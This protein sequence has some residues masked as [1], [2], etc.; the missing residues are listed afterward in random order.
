MTQQQAVTIKVVTIAIVTTCAATFPW[1][2][3]YDG[4]YQT[5]VNAAG[6][7]A[8]VIG[9]IAPIVMLFALRNEPTEESPGDYR[10]TGSTGLETA[11]HSVAQRMTPARRVL[12]KTRRRRQWAVVITAAGLA[13][14]AILCTLERQR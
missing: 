8:A 9:T 6:W 3:S 10:H 7:G 2:L 13:A 11:D 12:T 4:N 1:L 5:L 14:L